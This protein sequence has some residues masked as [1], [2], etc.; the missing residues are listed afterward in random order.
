MEGVLGRERGRG[1]RLLVLKFMVYRLVLMS[2]V[3]VGVL[4]RPKLK[5]FLKTKKLKSLK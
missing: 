5:T 2:L 4:T 1:R 3:E